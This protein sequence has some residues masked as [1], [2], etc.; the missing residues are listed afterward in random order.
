MQYIVYTVQCVF[1]K[2]I[3]VIHKKVRIPKW[4]WLFMLQHI[5]AGLLKRHA[6]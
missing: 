3:C 4:R 1:N 2:M 5:A 6:P